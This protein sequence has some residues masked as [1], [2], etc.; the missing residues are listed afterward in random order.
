MDDLF[1][2]VMVTGIAGIY[3]LITNTRLGLYLFLSL[4]VGTGYYLF[5]MK[6][7]NDQR[8]MIGNPTVN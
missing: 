6:I 5:L 8:I 7:T 4:S 3:W 1:Y 2:W